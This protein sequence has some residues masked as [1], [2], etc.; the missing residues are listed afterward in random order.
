MAVDELTAGREAYA[1][2]A[3]SAA[4]EHLS[5]ADPA[6]LG[7]DDLVAL[8]YSAY[9]SGDRDAAVRALQR[10]H[11][12]H[13]AAGDHLAAAYDAHQL[14]MIFA[15][16]GEP[17]VGAGWLA[18]AHRL[19]EDEPDDARERGYLLIHEM[20][21]RLGTGDFAAAAA[22][23][24]RIAEIGRRWND[25]D[26]VAFA[27]ASLGR[28]LLLSGQVREGLARLDEAMV[29]LTTG[30][31]SPIM[32]G[33]V[34]CSMIEGC[35]EIADFQRMTEWTDALVRWCEDQPGLVAFTGQCAVHRG[36]ILR[37][38][39]SFTEALDELSL[40]A[41]RY[42][43]NGMDPAIGLAM[44]ERGEVLRT[45]GDLD[46]AEAA[47]EDAARWGCEPQ[48]G[49]ALLSLARGRTTAAV[50][51]VHRLLDEARDPVTRSRRLSAVVEVLVAAGE[52]DA[53]QEASD[54]L[55]SLAQAFGSA[56]IS[57]KASYAAGLV[58]LA[59]GD[60][61]G[62]L[63]QFRRAW[64]AWIGLGARYDAARARV[65]IGL[66]LRSL[67]D[68]ASA[69]SELSLALRTFSELGT[70]PARREVARLLAAGLPD[71]LTPREV[72]VL[73]LVASG[74]S[75]PQVAATLFL[76]EKTVARH[77]SNIFTK[78]GVTSRTAAAAYAH[79]HDLA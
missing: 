55:G 64:K 2:R 56:A 25:A 29:E 51:S 38:H 32:A 18:R 70:E 45:L 36:Q 79:A 37:A 68:A 9:L 11:S 4:R 67:G 8:G 48:P 5:R 12:L 63:A 24:E 74:Q 7:A 30:E 43:A 40:A 13:V 52:L 34:Y 57:A 26:L 54:E 61:A 71:G 6:T 15:S 27:S 10:A 23:S 75:N 3:W 66:A 65:R 16:R 42:A 59:R 77:L 22:T 78:T 50:A 76:S 39:G 49:L 60:P 62:S 72:E 31:V 44:Y 21:Q 19:V 46:A 53:A 58:S 20:F 41:E 47:Y 69:T 35:Q 14:A 17:A 28:C 1:R 33:H 73:R